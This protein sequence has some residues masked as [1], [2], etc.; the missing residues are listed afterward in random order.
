MI[1]IELEK[2][3]HCPSVDFILGDPRTL[4]ASI[5]TYNS[6]MPELALSMQSGQVSRLEVNKKKV[7]RPV[8]NDY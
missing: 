2:K 3:M 4:Q 8:K 7:S 6:L 5:F 1:Y